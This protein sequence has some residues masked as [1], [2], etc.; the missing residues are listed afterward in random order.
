MAAV[1]LAVEG[2]MD[3]EQGPTVDHAILYASPCA[4][5]RGSKPSCEQNRL[6]G[7]ALHLKTI[8]L[9][10]TRS[11][12]TYFAPTAYATGH[13]PWSGSE[14]EGLA[15]GARV[16]AHDPRSVQAC[17]HASPDPGSKPA[18]GHQ[19]LAGYAAHV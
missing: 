9:L 7:W 17:F 10:D 8:P 2:A 4:V 14:L 15:V 18:R 13:P 16:P 1:G 6:V 19:P 3:P 11:P 5:E 12:A